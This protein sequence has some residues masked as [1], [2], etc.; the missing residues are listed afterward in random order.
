MLKVL[1]VA[2]YIVNYSNKKEYGIS[3]L[4]LQKLLY[5]VQACYLSLTEE[6]SP[7]FGD[8]IEAMDFGPFIPV[9]Y[10][11]F[12]KFG[13]SNIS[14]I[15]KYYTFENDSIWSIEIHD[16]DENIIPDK[17]KKYI[18]IVVDAFSDYSTIDMMKLIHNQKPWR[19]AYYKRGK[20][21][22]ITQISIKEYFK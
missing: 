22:E 17:D 19:D 16:F 9:V 7:C 10:N 1:D 2:R 8:K 20:N 14:P 4:R 6:E 13:N 3:N 15:S 5:F 18:E 21:A 12:K 11:E